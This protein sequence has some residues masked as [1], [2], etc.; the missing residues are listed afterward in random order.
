MY[1]NWVDAAQFLAAPFAM[2]LILAGIHCYLGLHV[3]ARGVIFVDLSLAQ[4]AAFGAT[5]AILFGFDHHSL[6][7]YFVSLGST[8]LAAALFAMARKH[9]KLFSQ[10]AIIGIVY[11]LASAAVVLVVDRIAHGAEHIKDLLV[12]QVLWVTWHDV[13]KTGLI[14]S[15]VAAI[16]FIYRKQLISASFSLHSRAQGFWDFIFYALFGVVITSS[17][18]MAGVLQVFAY[19]IVPA[20]VGTLFFKSIQA[21][22]LFGWGLG[23]VV[24]FIAMILSYAWDL[25][26]GAFIVVCFASIPVLLLVFSTL[27]R[28]TRR[29]I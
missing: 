26:A 10:E 3:L 19:L 23:F 7:T 16:H 24:S 14:Y 17:V 28:F 1:S 5:L 25:P 29:N 20:V 6:A 8:F 27:Y 12:G 21:R 11:A 22:L 2:C 15:A 13:I 4:V 9:E 18:S